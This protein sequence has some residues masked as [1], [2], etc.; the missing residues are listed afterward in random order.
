MIKGLDYKFTATYEEDN[1]GKH[2]YYLNG[3]ELIGCTTLLKKHNLAPKYDAV[4]DETLTKASE[5]GKL[6]H[7]ELELF[8]KN[9]EVSFAQEQKNFEAWINENAKKGNNI[10]FVESEMKVNNDLVAG[11]IDFIYE[12]N[13]ELV[14]ADFKTT[15]QVHKEAVSWQLSIYRELLGMEIKK[16][17]CFHL[18]GGLFEVIDIPL[19]TKEEVERLFD[20]ERK[21][22]IYKPFDLI[23]S[24]S[25]EALMDFQLQLMAMDEAKKKIENQMEAFKKYVMQEME[26]RGLLNY[27][28]IC[29][30]IELSLTRVLESKREDIDKKQLKA[31][32][33]EIYDKYKKT[34]TTKSYVKVSCKP[35]E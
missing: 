34:T 13:E 24:D 14:I 18:K 20:A 30:G 5:Y 17:V 23:P 6:V 8:I 27:K 7:R 4:D 29:N 11:T 31:D 26:A 35:V 1:T 2:H 32:M 3:V 10:V 33:P 25:V 9:D 21:G 22:E 15:S 28:V 19:K 12:E 16:G